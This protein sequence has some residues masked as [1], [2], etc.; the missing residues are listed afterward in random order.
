MEV[1]LKMVV[2]VPLMFFNET[3]KIYFGNQICPLKKFGNYI[4]SLTKMASL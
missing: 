1:I 4:S 3:S 2:V